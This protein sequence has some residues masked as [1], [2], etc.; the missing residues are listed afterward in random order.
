MTM[1]HGGIYAAS[2][3]KGF[4]LL[5]CLACILSGC[6]YD[7][8]L[9]GEKYRTRERS[10]GLIDEGKQL[11]KSGSLVLALDRYNRSASIYESSDAY[12]RMGR[13]FEALGKAREA[14]TAYQQALRLTPDYQEA[15]L[16]ILALGYAVP[17]YTP[18]PDDLNIA[19]QQ[20]AQ[21]KRELT[22]LLA[23]ANALKSH[24][25]ETS[26]T[27]PTAEDLKTERDEAL[28]GGAQKSQP[29]DEE[30][31][32][33]LFSTESEAT[34]PT[35]SKPAY[36][37]DRDIIIGTYPYHYQKAQ[38]FRRRQQYDKAAEEYER[39]IQADPKQ[40]Q[41][42]LDIGDMMMR[43]E[44]YQPALVYYQQALAAFPDSPRPLLKIGNYHL[45]LKQPDKARQFY[46]QALDKDPQYVESYNNLA[47]LDM[48]EKNFTEAAKM[49]D[50]IIKMEPSYTNA[51]LNRGIIASDVEHNRDAALQ[52]YKKYVELNGPRKD[53]V[54]G[55]I[56]ELENPER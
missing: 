38:Q 40:I 29:T 48:S 17:G 39:A 56:K 51:Y 28:A 2:L 5:G 16:A 42:R 10:L 47:V 41:A 12:F 23:T 15:R 35:A 24:N 43:L 3:R 30:V 37:S 49:L 7:N 27:A 46:R 45:T 22:T 32:G 19:S 13:V 1:A 50:E 55:W 8:L 54:Q 6:A 52:Y 36:A 25:V 53:Q 18:T 20:S 21:R 14:A 11:E 26:E 33:A 34:L 4:L 9:R 44:R 31:R